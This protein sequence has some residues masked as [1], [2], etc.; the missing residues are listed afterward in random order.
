MATRLV[1]N[2][3]VSSVIA[4]LSRRLPANRNSQQNFYQM[5]NDVGAEC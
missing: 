3:F 1:E 2:H 5:A 4:L